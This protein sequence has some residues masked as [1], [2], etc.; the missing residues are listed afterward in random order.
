MS[1][2]QVNL[3]KDTAVTG[4]TN[5]THQ[6]PRQAKAQPVAAP[7]STAAVGKLMTG[8]NWVV[9]NQLQRSDNGGI[10]GSPVVFH[11]PLENSSSSGEGEGGENKVGPSSSTL[12][13][14][15][16]QQPLDGPASRTGSQQQ[17]LVPRQQS[18]G[19]VPQQ[20]SEDTSAPSVKPSSLIGGDDPLFLGSDN[21]HEE[22]RKVGNDFVWNL[23]DELAREMASHYDA[24]E[25][26]LDP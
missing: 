6:P 13:P 16:T 2:F 3:N 17:D 21:I 26:A 14:Y 5:T 1:Q 7:P 18:W 12:G 4:I 10:L 22:L 20:K 9:Q 11:S 15:L 19:G 23:D 25:S 8:A 24:F